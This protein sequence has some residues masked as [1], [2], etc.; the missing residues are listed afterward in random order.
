MP[1]DI[2]KAY[3]EHERRDFSKTVSKCTITIIM[4]DL[5]NL[6][7]V[8]Q[9]VALGD[10]F[11]RTKIFVRSNLD[12]FPSMCLPGSNML[13]F[14]DISSAGK[15]WQYMLICNASRLM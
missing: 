2:T 10:K 9:T 14:E 12:V 4:L 6:T 3:G 15:H 5:F 13:I 8:T 1:P 7:V 11:K